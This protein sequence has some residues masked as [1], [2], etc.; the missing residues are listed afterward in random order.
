MKVGTSDFSLWAEEGVNIWQ[1]ANAKNLNAIIN[2][3]LEFFNVN[4]TQFFTNWEK[5]VF[6]LITANTFG[7]NVWGK[8]LGVERP[9]IPAVN[10]G[11]D[12]NGIFRFAN[13]DTHR[14]HSIWIS[15]ALAPTLNIEYEP[16][17]DVI[18]LPNQLGDDAYRTVLLAKI[19]LLYSNGSVHDINDFLQRLLGTYS[20]EKGWIKNESVYIQDNY[21]MT[22]TVKFNHLPSSATLSILT[23]DGL[24][25]RPAGVFLNYAVESNEGAFGF[26]E[27]EMNTWVE[28]SSTGINVPEGYGYL[29][30]T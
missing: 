11:I 27:A 28:P 25:P 23:T 10:G 29:T 5:D 4:V 17:L 6:N 13:L 8:I 26:A 30:T 22:M 21:N 9:S 16:S 20:P 1:Y 3:E 14:W 12:Q 7:L 24:S 15:G 18:P 19:R 2:D